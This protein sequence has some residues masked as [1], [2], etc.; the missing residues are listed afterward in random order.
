[1]D[2]VS[3]IRLFV[4]FRVSVGL[5]PYYYGNWLFVPGY[6]WGWQ[7]G[8]FS[9]WQPVPTVTNPPARTGLPQPP[10]A[11]GHGTVTVGK[12]P[13]LPVGGA[14]AEDHDQPRI[15]WTGNP[16]RSSEGSSQGLASGS[17]EGNGHNSHQLEF[18]VGD[19]VAERFRV[20]RRVDARRDDLS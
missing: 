1:M 6:G 17:A 14:A 19:G 2:V 13:V 20:I 5:M 4:R 10:T 7:P 12:G 8:G 15:G 18:P 9:S 11:P 3:G 16:A